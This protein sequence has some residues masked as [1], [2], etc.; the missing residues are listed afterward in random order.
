MSKTR[1]FFAAVVLSGLAVT[2]CNKSA[3]LLDGAVADA[4]AEAPMDAELDSAELDSAEVDAS[5]ADADA[6]VAIL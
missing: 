1:D 6:F 4:D 3:T 2:G 5:D